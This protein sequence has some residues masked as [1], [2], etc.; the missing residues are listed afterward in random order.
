MNWKVLLLGSVF[1]SG[2]SFLQPKTPPPETIFVKHDIPIQRRPE[3]LDLLD[4]TFDVVNK[5]NLETY[6]YENERRNN[7]L[8]F[9]AM[10]VV[11]YENLSLNMAE[12]KR[13]ILAQKALLDYYETQLTEEPENAEAP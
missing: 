13:Y 12:I 7:G 8:V 3:P 2:C 5:S 11:T 4:V 1:L 9:V 10:D 6:I